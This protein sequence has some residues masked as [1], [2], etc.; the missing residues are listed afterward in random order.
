MTDTMFP[1][2]PAQDNLVDKAANQ[3]TKAVDAT[4]G[5]ATA[6]LDSVSQKVESVRG[7]LSPAL[8][9]AL[10]PVDSVLRF[11]HE[12]PIGALMASAAVGA[13]LAT[14]LRHR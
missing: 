12:H 3:A 11:T 9:R 10:A 2:S 6:A 14:L 8:D 5:A 13:M 1:S 7:T 4:K